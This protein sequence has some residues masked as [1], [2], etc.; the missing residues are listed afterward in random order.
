MNKLKL[1]GLHLK[2]SKFR[3][4]LIIYLLKKYILILF[5]SGFIA[6]HLKLVSLCGGRLQ[7]SGVITYTD[8]NKQNYTVGK[9][10]F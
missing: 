1:G 2:Q 8:C 7:C 6:R 10:Y 9:S 3:L 5:N 4:E